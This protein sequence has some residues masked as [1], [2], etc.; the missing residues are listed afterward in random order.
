MKYYYNTYLTS[1]VI[2]NEYLQ[3][4]IWDGNCSAYFGLGA[5]FL[6]DI[7]SITFLYDLWLPM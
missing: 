2:V 7:K 4:L 6:D 1:K 3:H 5:K